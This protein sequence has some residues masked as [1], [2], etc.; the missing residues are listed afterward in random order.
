MPSAQSA[1][2]SPR[3]DRIDVVT[4]AHPHGDELLKPHTSRTT[5]A[6]HPSPLGATPAF[7]GVNFALYSAHATAVFLLLYDAADENPTDVIA[8]DGPAE[9]TWHVHVDGVR[10]GQLYAY[11]VDGPYEPAA[12][13]RFNPAKVVLDPYAKAV[14]GKFRNIDNLLLAYDPAV[15]P[16]ELTLDQRDSNSVVPKAVVVDDDAFDWRDDTAP[17]IVLEELIIYEV[18]AKGFT[19]THRRGSARPEPISDSSRRSPTSSSWAST[20]SSCCRYTSTTST[21]SSSTEG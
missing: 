7:G 5:A 15:G 10:P 19:A 4:Q 1:G 11:R 17:D 6:G 16:A 8:L 12:G 18:H 3:R 14:T 2:T 9:G 20:R 21:T 13:L